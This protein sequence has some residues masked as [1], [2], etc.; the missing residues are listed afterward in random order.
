LTFSDL[1]LISNKRMLNDNV[2]N[3]VQKMIKLKY[4]DIGGLQDPVLG[5]TLNFDVYKNKEFVQV[6]HNGNIH[7]IAIS[8]VN[9]L[10]KT[11]FLI[12]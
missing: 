6:L 2:I 3:A 10:P 8:T 1:K 9:C 12:G 7:W 11:C 4:P 5:E